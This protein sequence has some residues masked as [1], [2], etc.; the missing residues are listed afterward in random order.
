MLKTRGKLNRSNYISTAREHIR[1]L[2][3]I[4]DRD[5]FQRGA[6]V[7]VMAE[8]RCNHE[9]AFAACVHSWRPPH[10]SPVP[11]RRCRVLDMRHHPQQ[12]DGV[13]GVRAGGAGLV[14]SQADVAMQSREC[15]CGMCALLE[16]AT[17]ISSS[18]RPRHAASPTT[19]RW[20]LWREGR[21]CGPGLQSGRCGDAITR[22][23]L[24]TGSNRRIWR[25]TGATVHST[26]IRRIQIMTRV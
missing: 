1:I 6:D 12:V 16:A 15:L 17:H 21:R 8:W 10:T 2:A 18:S 19:G 13:Y 7:K 3:K 11:P 22:M 24:R 26:L 5:V 14:F 4:T 25:R 23:P 9:N 20:C